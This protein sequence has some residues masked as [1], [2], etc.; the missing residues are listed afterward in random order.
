[1]KITKRHLNQLC[2]DFRQHYVNDTQ[3][4]LDDREYIALCYLK[5]VA[6]LLKIK[7]ELI[8]P[9]PKV[10]LGDDE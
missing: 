4:D 1:M 9:K 8:Y 3:G 10:V 5:A 7:E 2:D 6:N